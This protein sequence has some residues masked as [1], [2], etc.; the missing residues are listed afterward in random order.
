MSQYY[1]N[2]KGLK[3]IIA[4]GGHPELGAAGPSSLADLKTSFFFHLEREL[5]KVNG[6]Y[7]QKE[8]E[9]QSRLQT[10]LDKKARILSVAAKTVGTAASA[11]LSATVAI[12][13]EVAAACHPSTLASL[14]EA[15]GQFQRDLEKLQKFVELN[16]MGFVKIL[17]KWDKRSKSST[18]E[19]YLARQVEV[20]PCFNGEV[21]AEL[22]DTAAGHYAELDTMLVQCLEA[23]AHAMAA[24]G[25]EG[26]VSVA[27]GPGMLGDP[28][29]MSAQEKAEGFLSKAIFKRNLPGIRFGVER[30]VAVARE[31]AA[32]QAPAA[33]P[34]AALARLV[35]VLSDAFHR[36]IKEC[37]GVEV[38][39]ALADAARDHGIPLNVNHQEEI[40]LRTCLHDAA[41]TGKFD[42]L[43]LCLAQGSEVRAVDVYGRNVLHHS[44]MYGHVESLRHLL[45]IPGGCDVNVPDYEGSTPL[46]YGI[47]EG[48]AG[49]VEVLLQAGAA[50][51][52]TSPGAPLPLSLACEYGMYDIAKLLL[53]QGAPLDANNEGLYPLHLASRQGHRTLTQLLLQHGAPLEQQD[54]MQ[55]WTPL[56]YSASEGHTACTRMLLDAGARV[57]VRDELG[58]YPWTYAL[59]RGHIQHA[60]WLRLPE[61]VMDQPM[62]V[63]HDASAASVRLRSASSVS[64]TALNFASSTALGI[65]ASPGYMTMASVPPFSHVSDRSPRGLA[66]AMDAFSLD[67]SGDLMPLALPP[68]ILPVRIYGH[69]YLTDQARV[70]ISFQLRN[71]LANVR[72]FDSKVSSLK[73]IITQKPDQAIPYTV[74]LP[75]KDDA[76]VYS[77]LVRDLTTFSIQFD[78][79]PT[80]G[81]KVIAKAIALSSQLQNAMRLSPTGAGEPIRFICPLFDV[82][83]RVVGQ[84]DFWFSLIQ[85]FL[86]PN[87]SIG[88]KTDTYWKATMMTA[89]AGPVT[90]SVLDAGAGPCSVQ[91][92]ITA[93]SLAHDYLVI[94]VQMSADGVPVVCRD[95]ALPIT[96]GPGYTPILLMSPTLLTWAQ[97]RALFGASANGAQLDEG[98]FRPDASLTELAAAVYQGYRSL[99]SVLR[100]C[101]FAL[102]I[103]FAQRSHN[104]ARSPAHRTCHHMWGSAYALGT[105]RRV[106]LKHTAPNMSLASPT[107]M[108]LWT[109]S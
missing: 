80:F 9:L 27:S 16:N 1:I 36:S 62:A 14:K 78:I 86:H 90:P 107:S 42:I 11:A 65:D 102:M 69:S 83:L 19:L 67:A 51:G 15:F 43:R 5:E 106:R 61:E 37:P 55:S 68:P 100:V 70:H 49:I 85:P 71:S 10:L 81:T 52:P 12:V 22:A 89:S 93:T 28:G 31:L 101:I 41:L 72:L 44:A 46:V 54:T 53:Q 63:P 7:V 40:S 75:A 59:Y 96:P 21:L 50:L 56:F 87:L 38:S 23:A 57:D 32:I 88:G 45:A 29:V 30:L 84:L 20:Q 97:G 17:K 26:E 94:V 64:G 33:L 103:S 24:A 74:I 3:K 109:A 108:F 4:G 48:L 104:H 6:L 18:K 92:F 98:G 91:S 35:S 105:R 76:E 13:A 60:D 39:L 8:A 82:R 77:F 79:Y 99:S 66:Q 58:W 95:W 47:K 73:V 34:P 2:Y 25:G